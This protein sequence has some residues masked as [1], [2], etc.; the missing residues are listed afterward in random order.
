MLSPPRVV[1]DEPADVDGALEFLRRV[2]ARF[3]DR[4]VLVS[5][6]GP[7]SL[8]VLDLLAELGRP[9]RVVFL[10]TEAHFPET[11]TLRERVQARYGVEVE[12]V[13]PV[14]V[15]DRH[16]AADPAACCEAR[17]VE[18]LR[19]ILVRYDAWISGVR[20]DQTAARAEARAIA[21]DDAYG[22]WKVNPLVGWTRAQVL[23]EIARRGVPVNALLARG[24]GSVGCAPCTRPSVAERGGRFVGQ[25]RDEC[26]IH[27]RPARAAGGAA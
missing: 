1:P 18:P 7:Q 19:R 17:K 22:L 20:A 21:W 4:L 16:W 14:V 24:Y 23:A 9:P 15:I 11:L 13:A 8:L 10:D 5:G 25:G 2:V 26:G 3:T 6:L 12:P 27:A